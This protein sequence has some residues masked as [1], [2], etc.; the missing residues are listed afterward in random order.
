MN[1]LKP[2]LQLLLLLGRAFRRLSELTMLRPA[3]ME[4]RLQGLRAY[5]A[6]LKMEGVKLIRSGAAL[7]S[8]RGRASEGFALPVSVLRGVLEI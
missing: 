7:V 2:V 8:P 3:P 1:D 5:I 6:R 4:F